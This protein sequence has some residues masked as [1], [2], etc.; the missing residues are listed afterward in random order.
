MVS[1]KRQKNIVSAVGNNA[2]EVKNNQRFAGARNQSIGMEQAQFNFVQCFFLE[3]W[4]ERNE[5]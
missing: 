4:I 2:R 5:R 3:R 1:P